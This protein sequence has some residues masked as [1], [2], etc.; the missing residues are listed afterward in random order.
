M[1]KFKPLSYKSYT[2]GV[3]DYPPWAN[4]VGWLIGVSSMILI[5]AT[6]L[7]FIMT[8]HGSWSQVPREKFQNLKNN[9]GS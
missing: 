7:Y 3:Y 1:V 6:G 4:G 8:N 2:L 5:P 9:V